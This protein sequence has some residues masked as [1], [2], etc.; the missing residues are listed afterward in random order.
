ML[1]FV[2]A[3]LLVILA[4]EALAQTPR[5]FYAVSMQTNKTGMFVL[6]TW[7]VAN[8]ATGGIGWSG[9]Q[10]SQKY[11][12]QMNVMWNAVNLGIA[13][14]AFYSFSLSDPL[15]M[16]AGEMLRD[17]VRKENL[18]L[19]NAGLDVLYIGGGLYMRRLASD[20]HRRADMLRGYG[21]SVILQ[22]GFLM[23]FDLAMYLIQRQ[24]RLNYDPDMFAL[25]LGLTGDGLGL[26][27][28]F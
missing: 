23:A 14:A 4:G 24:H 1:R 19:I 9:A 12:H 6:G 15:T 27:L 22:G 25:Q 21:T 5:E 11:F 2:F 7:A 17:H 18:Y 16:S 28:R 8:I 13:G 10:G 26:V 3:L 20:G